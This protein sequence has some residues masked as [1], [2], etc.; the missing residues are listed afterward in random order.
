M[1]QSLLIPVLGKRPLFLSFIMFPFILINPLQSLK[2]TS[3]KEFQN[4]YKE[5][6]IFH[7]AFTPMVIN[8][9]KITSKE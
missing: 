6:D 9:F 3:T 8:T 4:N 7:I 1:S 2:F 5:M